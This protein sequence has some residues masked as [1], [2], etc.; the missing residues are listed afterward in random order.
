MAA[1][2]ALNT[3]MVKEILP[4][5]AT[6][7][8][9]R[10]S[11]TLALMRR[12]AKVYGGGAF[13]SNPFLYG[14]LFGGSYAKGDTFTLTKPQIIQATSFDPK[15]YYANVT[16][17]L[18]EITVENNPKSRLGVMSL[19]DLD[20]QAALMTI[21]EIVAIALWRHGQASGGAI[22]DSR[23][24]D[25]NGF[26]EAFNDGVTNSWD[27]NVFTSY[28]TITRNSTVGSSLNSVPYWGGDQLGNPGSITYN[29][30]RDRYTRSTR[31][32][33]MPDLIVSNKAGV[34]FIDE[35]IQ[36]QQRFGQEKDPVW[37]VP[38][39]RFMAAYIMQDDYCPSA[40]FGVNDSITGNYLTSSF[41]SAASPAADS[42][43][44]ASTT[45]TV[46]EVIFM[47]NTKYSLIR[48]SDQPLYNFG[49]TGFKPA[50]NSTVVAGQ[51]LFAVNL[52]QLAPYTG[53]Q[54]F[55]FNS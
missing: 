40:I 50:Q 29:V 30:M 51:V 11:P 2:D 16:E 6:D 8:V 37:G 43:M 55:G 52:N 22:V 46:G 7:L 17:Y 24:K 36:P 25:I 45:L 38:T 54:L 39:P 4:K 42:N 27:G 32:P 31:G 53:Q 34:A 41:T 48:L 47:L 10:N 14:K 21:N 44:P 20:C 12:N 1:T 35:R 18:E 9:F 33:I 5:R 28:G 3:I 19:V 15:Y 49:W 23:P 13:M 26:S